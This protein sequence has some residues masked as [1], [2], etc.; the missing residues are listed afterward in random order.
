MMMYIGWFFFEIGLGARDSLRLEA[1]LCLHGN[2]ISDYTTPSE[3]G[4][5]ENNNHKNF[6]FL[7][8]LISNFFK[9]FLKHFSL[10]KISH[11]L[12]FWVF[13]SSR[14]HVDD[15]RSKNSKKKRSRVC[16]S[17]RVFEGGWKIKKT[18]KE[19]GWINGNESTSSTSNRLWH[20]LMTH[21][22]KSIKSTNQINEW[23]IIGDYHPNF[24]WSRCWNCNLW[25]HLL[26]SSF[27]IFFM[28][29]TRWLI[30]SHTYILF[31]PLIDRNNHSII[32]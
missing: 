18:W 25:F 19:E 28:P 10:Q 17:G 4:C 31:I 5:H 6:S 13:Q 12:S 7:S 1:G 8:H 11:D 3:A 24:G 2:D 29:L 22:F 9:I 21:N 23:M 26:F 27:L 30:H 32:R 16:G 14:S 15:W 20:D